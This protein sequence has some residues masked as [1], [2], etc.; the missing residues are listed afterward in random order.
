VP[1]FLSTYTNKI[2]KKGRVSVP[3]QFRAVLS[4]ENFPGIIAYPSFVNACIEA[5]G[6]ARIE[7]L[8]ESIDNLDPFS[9]ERDAFATSILGGS[10]QL[11][12]DSEGRVSISEELI[13][14]AKL[15]EKAV[16]V[17]KGATFEIWDP[18]TFEEYSTAA[19]ELAKKQRA[20]LSL[21]SKNRGGDND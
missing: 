18:A 19:R 5:S 9:D 20:V 2:D 10:Q 12:F 6:M 15:T 21:T 17:G 14:T 8:S 16:F 13:A 4:A 1:L 11:A 3:A 7:R